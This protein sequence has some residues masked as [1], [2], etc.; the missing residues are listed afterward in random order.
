MTEAILNQIT[1]LSGKG[2]T[3]KTTITAA[4]AQLS[5]PNCVVADCDVDAPN[6]HL[7]LKPQNISSDRFFSGKIAIKDSTKC[8]NCGKCLEVCRFDAISA[9]FDIDPVSCEGCGAC[10]W[11]C[12]K[13]AITMETQVSGTI[14]EAKSRFGSMVHARLD[15]GAENSGKLVNEVIRRSHDL[16]KKLDKDLV[17]VDGSPG[18]GCP[19]ISSLTNA[20]LVIIVVEP[21]STAIHDMK[22]VLELVRF[23]KLKPAVIINKSTINLEQKQN[24]VTFCEQEDV[25]ILGELPYDTEIY[26]AMVEGKTVIEYGLEGIAQSLNSVW[27]MIK[28]TLFQK[29]TD[30]NNGTK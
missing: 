1:V 26:R 9:T 12:P 7:L 2:G 29:R 11:I 8:I 16:A 23:F 10:A 22:R 18:I 4:L 19:V 25:T 24:I 28:E 30:N 20:T 13:K 15:I 14:Y 5:S 27:S 6:L 17:I 3:G 21:T